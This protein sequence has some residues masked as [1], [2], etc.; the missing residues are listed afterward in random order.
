MVV[1]T[2]SIPATRPSFLV[3]EKNGAV[4]LTTGETRKG[5]TWMSSVEKS[6]RL[7]GP[8]SPAARRPSP[9]DKRRRG[10]VGPA[11]VRYRVSGP[12]G[13][14]TRTGA[15]VSVSIRSGRVCSRVGSVADVRSA[16]E[17]SATGGLL[18]YVKL[19]SEL[20]DMVQ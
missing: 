17:R 15:A 18:R 7:L 9:G 6:M 14:A 10:A 19:G 11:T 20:A 5:P 8:G 13:R 2:Q 12:F 4:E 16:G 3:R 1:A